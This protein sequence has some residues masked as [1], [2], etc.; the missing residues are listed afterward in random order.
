MSVEGG[1]KKEFNFTDQIL[2]SSFPLSSF[3]VIINPENQVSINGV[4]V[5]LHKGSFPMLHDPPLPA[6]LL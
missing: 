2:P 5:P 4:S 3:A 6:G 1:E